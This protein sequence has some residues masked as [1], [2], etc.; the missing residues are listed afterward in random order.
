MAADASQAPTLSNQDDSLL[1]LLLGTQL[2]GANGG[3]F[4]GVQG[5]CNAGK[6]LVGGRPL[7]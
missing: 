3:I 1:V 7:A 2:V 4:T 5:T 6:I